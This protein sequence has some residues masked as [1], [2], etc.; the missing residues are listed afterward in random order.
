MGLDLVAMV[1]VA[2][3][4]RMVMVVLLCLAGLLRLLL[5]RRASPHLVVMWLLRAIGD[6]TNRSTEVYDGELATTP[7]TIVRQQHR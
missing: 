2:R 1:L 4:R 3:L 6:H 7:S 5:L